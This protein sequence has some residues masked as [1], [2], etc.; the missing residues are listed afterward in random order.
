MINYGDVS[1]ANLAITDPDA[2]IQA[3]RRAVQRVGTILFNSQEDAAGSINSL[4]VQ[5][6]DNSGVIRDAADITVTFQVQN[7]RSSDVVK[8]D[9]LTRQLM[10]FALG[11][12]L[13]EKN[14]GQPQQ[15]SLTQKVRVR[16]L[17]R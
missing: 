11:V 15:V 12:R 13:Y 17:Q 10:T 1:N 8:A 5:Y 3:M 2:R 16:N 4:P 7:N 6:V 14:S 9:Y